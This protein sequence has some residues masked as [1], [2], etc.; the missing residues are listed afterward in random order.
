M[1]I[2]PSRATRVS[3]LTPDDRLMMAAM[4]EAGDAMQV[5]I[6]DAGED[7]LGEAN[8]GDS[9]DRFEHRMNVAALLHAFDP[10]VLFESPDMH[11]LG[12]VLEHCTVTTVDGL[13]SQWVL[14]LD[15]RQRRLLLLLR[16]GGE[17]ASAKRH[18]L[19]YLEAT[20]ETQDT[21]ARLL[22]RLL[23]QEW[24]T[25]RDVDGY[26]PVEL[27]AL[28]AVLTW[29]TPLGKAFQEGTV[30]IAPA[31]DRAELLEPFRFLTGWS[32]Q[33]RADTFVGR[34]SELE[35]LRRHVDVIAADGFFN[36][37]TRSAQ[38]LTQTDSRLLVCS[39]V[40]GVGKSTLL[41]KFILE[42]V[43]SAATP[44]LCFAY[45]D[46]DRSSL[47]PLQ[48]V[49]L[50]LEAIRQLAAQL[51]DRSTALQLLRARVRA[52]TDRLDRGS[53]MGDRFE[54]ATE[55]LG[56]S[57][58]RKFLAEIRGLCERDGHALPMLVVIDTFEEVQLQ[59]QEAIRRVEYFLERLQEQIPSAR[60]VVV[61]RDEVADAFRGADRLTLL[62]FRD[63]QS[64]QEFLVRRGVPPAIAGRVA[65]QVGGRPLSLHLAARLVRQ[66]GERA[67]S[68]SI[69]SR[70]RQLFDASLI[71]AVLYGRIL[72]HIKDKA[73]KE[74]V[75]PGLVLRRLDAE[76][77]RTVVAPVLAQ[78][79]AAGQ[80]NPGG[81]PTATW[82]SLSRADAERIMEQVRLQKDLVRTEADGSVT[83]RADVRT[84][85]LTLMRAEEPERTLA[86]HRAAAVYHQ[87]MARSN[88][89]D[90][91]RQRDVAEACYHWL[92]LGEKLEWV[93]QQW[94]PAVKGSLAAA[95]T[96]I[97]N[98][99]G[100][101]ALKVLLER[102]PTDAEWRALPQV[103]RRKSALRSIT[104]SVDAQ[105]P[106][107]AVE[108]L[109]LHER[110]LTA[111][112]HA[113]L[114]ARV[115]DLSGD[116]DLAREAWAR[117]LADVYPTPSQPEFLLAADFLERDPYSARQ[118]EAF[119]KKLAFTLREGVNMNSAEAATVRQFK[120]L[121][122][123][124]AIR[125]RLR[126]GER[127]SRRPSLSDV[128]VMFAESV[129]AGRPLRQSH[130]RWL[131]L[132]TTDLDQFPVPLSLVELTDTTRE[133]LS[134]LRAMF[135]QALQHPDDFQG[136]IDPA[137][138]SG[139]CDLLLLGGGMA[140]SRSQRRASFPPVNRDVLNRED[141]Q[142]V[143]RFVIRRLLLPATPQWYI[144]LAAQVRRRLGPRVSV[145]Q[146]LPSRLP[147]LPFST[148]PALSSTR[149]LADVFERLD[150]LGLLMACLS[151]NT[152]VAELPVV[153]AYR[154][155]RVDVLDDLDKE[156][157]LSSR[158]IGIRSA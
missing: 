48:P 64:R 97:Q 153:A 122:A 95:V 86:L 74:M 138:G 15:E 18:A 147:E 39:G 103:Y 117:V 100:R 20:G 104:S 13:T 37:I 111:D 6:A 32:G 80:S 109:A 91:A 126:S 23:A 25:D 151:T 142:T 68:M 78:R 131:V 51:P 55:L 89:S 115:F 158:A 92:S 58:Q 113:T 49:T 141:W 63:Q 60:I 94:S 7:R 93:L 28:R 107:E 112:D 129:R 2:G 19:A 9:A 69:G 123:L 124:A 5:A 84:Q 14:R 44:P 82:D 135:V 41:A 116:W 66:H 70:F 118:R 149:E 17:L 71:D 99:A 73:V 139:V 143:V 98:I 72:E 46:F 108:R 114:R 56:L 30:S 16:E 85:M 156:F 53:R 79:V 36:R 77:L 47:Q 21:V 101:G 75:H 22:W 132:L 38:R 134:F 76:I 87:T 144:P 54:S 154:E 67:I 102:K 106:E 83:H 130:E 88:A 1:S 24:I 120:L 45:L 26:S 119:A 136:A 152:S 33:T 137:L 59:G 3:A 125:L 61:G 121:F 42:H 146:L 157:E 52:E 145:G 8:D 29:V 148:S 105:D 10:H 62:E 40:G 150:R 31:I 110:D 11:S 50:L 128:D 65:A 96:E 34:A 27:A 133:Q 43:S 90:A 35:R 12:K 127:S 4:M 155:W 140:T 57:L 81:S